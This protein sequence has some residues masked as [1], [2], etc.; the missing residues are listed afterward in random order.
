MCIISFT[1]GLVIGSVAG[2][3]GGVEWR[4]RHDNPYLELVKTA[5]DV[6]DWASGKAQKNKPKKTDAV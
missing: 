3:A 1:A 2:F 6:V 4:H 5:V